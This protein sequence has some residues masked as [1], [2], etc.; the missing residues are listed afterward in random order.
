MLIEMDDLTAKAQTWLRLDK[1]GLPLSDRLSPS[2]RYPYNTYLTLPRIPRPGPKWNPFLP[3]ETSLSLGT[4]LARV[5]IISTPV[6]LAVN[7]G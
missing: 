6:Y 4:A 5:S 2:L 7:G 3:I 1:V